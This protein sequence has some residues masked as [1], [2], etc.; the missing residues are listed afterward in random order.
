MNYELKYDNERGLIVG[1]IQGKFDS[2]LVSRMAADLADLVHKHGCTRILNDLRRADITPST[3][4]IYLMPKVVHQ[5]NVP[6]ICKRALV[7]R[8]PL[9]NYLFLETVSVN[10]GQAVRIFTDPKDAI[11]WLT[12]PA[13]TSDM[14]GANG[15]K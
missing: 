6:R 15:G 9:E 8:G 14:P 12:G 1:R 10:V 5:A 2:S 4:D 3:V 13:E 11:E 7:V